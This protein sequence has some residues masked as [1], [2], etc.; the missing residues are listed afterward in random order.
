M[1]RTLVYICEVFIQTQTQNNNMEAPNFTK[2]QAT[3][4]NIGFAQWLAKALDI[5]SG[6][7]AGLFVV[8]LRN[9][10]GNDPGPESK[11]LNSRIVTAQ[12][13]ARNEIK[14][15]IF[16]Y[17][18]D[19]LK[20]KWVSESEFKTPLDKVLIFQEIAEEIE[21][22][23]TKH[24]DWP[25]DIIHAAAIVGEESGEL[26]RAALQYIYEKGTLEAAKKEAIQTAVTAIRFLSHL[27]NY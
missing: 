20:N 3:G 10:L 25:A 23:E 6:V 1:F 7:N 14:R 13:R 19:L 4:N 21:R 17:S 22:A 24:P 26:T 18:P 15:A 16:D 12:Y 9:I 2:D 8:Y 11:R 27:H 5:L